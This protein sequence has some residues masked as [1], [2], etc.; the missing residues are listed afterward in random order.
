[1]QLNFLQSNWLRQY[2]FRAMNYVGDGGG[3]R[4]LQN[5]EI[6]T[7]II[8]ALRITCSASDL[9]VFI[10]KIYIKYGFIGITFT[11]SAGDLG[12]A[13]KNITDN[14]QSINIIGNTGGV[15]GSV[16]IGNAATLQTVKSY[17]FDA[18]SGAIEPSTIMVTGTPAVTSLS[19]KGVKYVGNLTF[20]SKTVSITNNATLNFT[21]INPNSVRSR[22]DKKAANLT[23]DQYVISGINSVVP[24]INGNIDVYTVSPLH[25]TKSRVTGVDQLSF[26]AA[27]LHMNNFFGNSLC[28]FVN[29]PPTNLSDDATIDMHDLAS[30]PE[31]TMWPA[32]TQTP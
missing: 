16:T 5:H 14:N 2:P 10:S 20:S 29:I 15:I 1:M 24:D 25:I 27:S 8:V 23:C 28:K 9:D 13:N 17:A 19:V 18:N 6:P 22:Q 4:D 12:Y 11:G 3:R 31:W 26:T 7:D 21:T 32:F 30:K